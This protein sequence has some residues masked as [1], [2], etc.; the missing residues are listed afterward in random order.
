MNGRTLGRFAAIFLVLVL[1]VGASA[2]VPGGNVLVVSDAETGE[3]LLTV[4]VS[5]GTTVAIEY[6]H[7]VEKTQVIDEYTVRGDELE[8]TRMVFHSFGA[9]LPARADVRHVN[10][11]YVFDPPGSY[12][13]FYVKPGHVAGH[14]LRVGD[15]TYDLVAL[16]DARSVR[17]SIEQRSLLDRALPAF[18]RQ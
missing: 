5:E 15:E 2:A 14:E 1:T 17:L 13:E 7:S 12:E 11:S 3:D 4:P 8:M 9:G 10:G 16:S 18:T 6:T